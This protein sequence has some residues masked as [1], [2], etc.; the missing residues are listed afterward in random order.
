MYFVK[1]MQQHLNT[2]TIKTRVG[3]GRSKVSFLMLKLTTNIE[4]ANFVKNEFICVKLRIITLHTEY[5]LLQ[6]HSYNLEA[7]EEE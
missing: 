5:F 7:A 4:F 1:Q 3:C 6:M 2:A